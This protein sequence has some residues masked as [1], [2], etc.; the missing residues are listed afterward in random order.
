MAWPFD[1]RLTNFSVGSIV[2]SET[3]NAMQDRIVD[4]HRNKYLLIDHGVPL[5]LDA[6]NNGTLQWARGD[7]RWTW[8]DTGA[9]ASVGPFLY[10]PI[11]HIS[12]ARIKSVDWKLNVSATCKAITT[13]S[14]VR[15]DMDYA[16]ATAAPSESV[17]EG[18]ALTALGGLTPGTWYKHSWTSLDYEMTDDYRFALFVGS[19]TTV[20]D[21]ACHFGFPRV[22]IQPITPT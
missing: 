13:L 10:L 18:Q 5:D 12:G 21:A 4:L 20:Q 9:A 15:T 1:A 22:E 11:P 14:L 17:V 8:D 2:P 6:V 19:L 3:L 16:N 7:G